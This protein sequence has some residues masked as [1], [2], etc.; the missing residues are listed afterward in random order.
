MVGPVNLEIRNKFSATYL[1]VEGF[2]KIKILYNKYIS[3]FKN[4][5][6]M[7]DDSQEWTKVFIDIMNREIQISKL[8]F[9]SFKT[10]IIIFNSVMHDRRKTAL[11][12]CKHLYRLGF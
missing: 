8:T 1:K 6:R 9:Q 11:N 7:M 4:L 12:Y 2:I 3:I 5:N 10:N